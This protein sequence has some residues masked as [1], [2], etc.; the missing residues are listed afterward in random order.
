MTPTCP[1]GKR[2]YRRRRDALLMPGRCSGREALHGATE[3]REHHFYRCVWCNR[4]HLTS[5]VR[6]TRRRAA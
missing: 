3:S 1:T 4:F 2:V 5:Q 6:P